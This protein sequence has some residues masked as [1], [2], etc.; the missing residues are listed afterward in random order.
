M[1]TMFRAAVLVNLLALLSC[2]FT[3][4][5]VPLVDHHQHL[6]SPA[7]AAMLGGGPDQSKGLS[8]RDLIVLLDEARIRRA[9]VLSVAYMYGSPFRQVDDEYAKVKEENDWTAAQAAEYPGR[10]RAFCGFNPLRDYAL[11]ELERCAATS[12]LRYGIKLHFAN[13][14]VRLDDPTHVEQL[15]KIFRA[16]NQHRMAIVVH[17][18]ANVS[19]NRP[20]GAEQARVFLSQVLPEAPDVPVQIAHLAGTGPGYH[21]LPA[22]QAMGVLAAAVQRR[23][24]RTRNL[25]FDVAGLASAPMTVD[26]MTQL[27]RRIRQ[28]GVDRILYGSDAAVSG[29]LPPR[30]QW[31]AFQKLPLT[32]KEL[33]RIARNVAPYMK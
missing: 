28:V 25:W 18:R 23:D 22:D 19:H 31:A 20:Y 4:P 13:S 14:D 16:A 24:A 2:G 10:L 29:N 3:G 5:I 9:V 8:A 32:E 27:V 6:F 15:R 11:A 17:L 7:I 30:E 26:E 12:G 33:T 21:D 1:T